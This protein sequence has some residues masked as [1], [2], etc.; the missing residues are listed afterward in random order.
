LKIKNLLNEGGITSCAKSEDFQST[1]D[2]EWRPEQG[3]G[4]TT[5]APIES[6]QKKVEV[7]N[8]LEDGCVGSE[9]TKYV[10][11]EL[12]R[13]GLDN[14][15]YR[16]ILHHKRHSIAKMLAYH[17]RIYK[18]GSPNLLLHQKLDWMWRMC[19]EHNIQPGSTGALRNLAIETAKIDWSPNAASTESGRA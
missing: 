7:T 18:N 8:G 2:L 15:T 16:T 4:P 13:L 6:A 9:Q 3:G 5:G 1:A 17:D 19:L 11:K 10:L 12:V 14:E